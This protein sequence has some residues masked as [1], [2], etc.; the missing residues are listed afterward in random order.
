M[1]DGRWGAIL[2]LTSYFLLSP[3]LLLL[4]I[5]ILI[6]ERRRDGGTERRDEAGSA[7]L[8]NWKARLDELRWKAALPHLPSPI[9][10]PPAPSPQ[11]PTTN[12]QLQGFYIT[13]RWGWI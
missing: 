3:E 2:F 6:A 4:L 10:Q 8:P 1:G 7:S 13:R 11:L 12:S 9:S 5:L